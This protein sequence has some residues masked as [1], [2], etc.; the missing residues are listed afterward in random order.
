MKILIAGDV[1]ATFNY[2]NAVINVEH[3]D[4][5]LACGDFG[6]WPSHGARYSFKNI[7]PQNSK[8]YWCD[9]NHEEHPAIKAKL[10]KG[11]TEFAPNVFYMP[12]GTVKNFP[13]LG[14][15]L[16]MGGADSID[17]G[18]R[19]PGYD[20]FPEEI[21]TQADLDL[22]PDTTVDTVIS[23]T[24]PTSIVEKLRYPYWQH[25]KCDDPSSVA[26]QIVLEKYNPCKWFFG[27]WHLHQY[28]RVGHTNWCAL[29]MFGGNTR[30]FVKEGDWNEHQN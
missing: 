24:A 11:I 10:D 14:N 2:L 6:Y 13:H 9:G 28:G 23:H 8:I 1:H 16:F 18:G 21:I 26:L 3:P 27:H 25:R 19:T 5:V 30:A 22:L 29:N 20:W 4:V 17:K 7:K 15:V 12:R